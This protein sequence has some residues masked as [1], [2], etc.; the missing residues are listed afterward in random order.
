MINNSIH[1]KPFMVYRAAAPV[2]WNMT[3]EQVAEKTG[4]PV[5]EVEKICLQKGWRLLNL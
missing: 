4:L 1:V 2:D 5:N 3:V